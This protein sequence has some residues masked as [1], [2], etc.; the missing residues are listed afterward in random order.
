M[1]EK[2]GWYIKLFFAWYDCWV[3]WYWDRS[4]RALYLCPLPMLCLM[5]KLPRRIHDY[6]W[7]DPRRCHWG[8]SIGAH[9]SA[10][11]QMAGNK[12]EI[13][14]RCHVVVPPEGAALSASEVAK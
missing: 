7:D 10:R 1:S 3:G 9:M 8:H 11:W 4:Q 13:C 6:E 14:S 12:G 2:Y 5:V